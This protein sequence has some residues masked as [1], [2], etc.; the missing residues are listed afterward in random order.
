MRV[1]LILALCAQG[2]FYRH[3]EPLNDVEWAF[4]QRVAV[5]FAERQGAPGKHLR[6]NLRVEYGDPG[7]GYHG[8]NRSKPLRKADV[9]VIRHDLNSRRATFVFAHE[10]LHTVAHDHGYPRGHD[11]DWAFGDS[12]D[13][14]QHVPYL[15]C[16]PEAVAYAEWYREN[17]NPAADPVDFCP[18]GEVK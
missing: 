10:V 12:P 8:V 2:C 3:S 13:A 18:T 5:A 6:P 7:E 17:I 14:I 16:W 11:P 9:L 15:D 4:A 1:V